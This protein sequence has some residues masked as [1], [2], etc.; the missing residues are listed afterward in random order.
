[1][2]DR[3]PSHPGARPRTLEFPFGAASKA[4]GAA[5]QLADDLDS[6]RWQVDTGLD[7]L[8]RSRFEGMFAD[9][10]LEK[11]SQLYDQMQSMATRLQDQA[12]DIE[13][14]TSGAGQRIEDRRDDILLWETRYHRWRSRE[15]S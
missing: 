6:L 10:M 11:G 15:P 9:W 7:D 5:R 13:G 12:E 3:R 1:M 14:Q 2:N 8:S 4:A